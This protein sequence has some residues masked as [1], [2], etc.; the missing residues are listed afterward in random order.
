MAEDEFAAGGTDGDESGGGVSGDVL[1]AVVRACAEGDRDP[2]RLARPLRVVVPSNALREHLAAEL[3]ARR[4]RA[5]A[6]SCLGVRIETLDAVAREVLERSGERPAP[7]L[8]TPI[9]VRELARREPSLAHELAGLDDGYAGVVASVDDLLDAGFTAALADAWREAIDEQASG[10]LRER[11]RALGRVAAGAS[12]ALAA[13]RLGHRSARLARAEVRLRAA[14]ADAAAARGP[15]PS[16]ALWIT[17]FADATGVQ[18]DL[19]ETLARLA[20][21]EVWL[22]EPVGGSRFGAGLRERLV[23]TGRVRGASAAPA[24]ELLASLHADPEDEARAAA[25]WARSRL[26]EGLVPE[27]IAIVARDLAPHRLALRRQLQRFGVPFSGSGE[28]GA[29]GPA[30][31][32]LDALVGLVERGAAFPAERWLDALPDEL[33]PPDLRDALHAAGIATLADLADAPSERWRS[34]VRI[35]ARTGLAAGDDARHAAARRVARAALDAAAARAR[36]TRA[37]LAA[38]PERAAFAAHVAQLRSLVAALG[39]SATTPG[40]VELSEVLADPERVGDTPVPREDWPRLLRRVLDDA[41]RD[42]LGGRGG[43]VQVLSVMEARG[44]RFDA[45]RAVGLVRGAF[46][47]RLGEDPLLPDALRRPLRAVLPD[48]PV[49]GDAHEE[50]RF[51]FGQLLR[52]APRV[53]LSCARTDAAGRAAVASPLFER[54]GVTPTDPDGAEWCSPRDAR[55]DA[56]LRDGRDAFAR[57]LPEALG[58]GRRAL[59]LPPVED[60]GLARARLA[61]LAELDPRDP[62]CASLG[63]YLGR[64]GPPRGDADPR[65]RPPSVTA[66]EAVARCPWKAFLQ[67]VLRIDPQP[68]VWRALPSAADP[69]LLGNAVHRALEELCLPGSAW[70]AEAPDAPIL[71]AARGVAA[72]AGIALPGYARALARAARPFVEVARALDREEEP[73]VLDVETRREVSLDG[74]DVPRSV[75]FTA[76]RVEEVDGVERFTDW[77]TGRAGVEAKTPAGR[78]NEHARK[79]ARGELLQGHVYA[80]TGARARYVFLRPDLDPRQ[81]VLP[82]VPDGP[83]REAFEASLAI[84]FE[85]REQGAF[86]PRL[87]RADR[88]EE[89]GACR[90][91]EVK[92]ACLRGDSGVRRRLA[93]WADAEPGDSPLERAALALWRLREGEA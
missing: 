28:R 23:A 59:A 63:P 49:K 75:Q 60:A 36:E 65:R 17:G 38:A 92:Q 7:D 70:P 83:Q 31:R 16:R 42:A 30:S 78:A 50:E 34:G 32:R 86:P 19:L 27:R 62:R 25:A 2:A 48:L 72:E 57:V 85:A 68:D 21:A 76:D 71:E 90:S 58:A 41:G 24:A 43:G 53:W 4:E 18:L 12:A 14:G 91:C 82:A 52:A 55:R 35:A 54:A 15:L 51:L 84:L 20:D 89:P 73:T 67:R 80:R 26:A 93:S 1:D 69:L 61:V 56:A 81:R 44:C 88:N 10:A 74:G 47:R 33:A 79:L 37:V 9:A 87:R 13:G 29:A 22:D 66:L 64:V 40:N 77:K 11:A 5:G 6:R 39:W 3:L 45:L 46:P 8:L